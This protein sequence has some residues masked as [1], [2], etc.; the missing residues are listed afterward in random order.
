MVARVAS[1]SKRAADDDDGPGRHGILKK[2][3]GSDQSVL[4]TAVSEYSYCTVERGRE[5]LGIVILC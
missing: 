1:S 3:K 5:D 2:T 4:K